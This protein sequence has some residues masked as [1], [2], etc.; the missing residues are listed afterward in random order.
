MSR[1]AAVEAQIAARNPEDQKALLIAKLEDRVIAMATGAESP[2]WETT[3]ESI[4]FVSDI[5][6]SMEQCYM[7]SDSSVFSRKQKKKIGIINSDEWLRF[8]IYVFQYMKTKGYLD[9]DTTEWED[10]AGGSDE[11]IQECMVEALET[12]E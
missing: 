12:Y 11:V 5:Y 10:T 7:Y 6:Y 2:P 4:K 3:G 8:I 9:G 1:Q